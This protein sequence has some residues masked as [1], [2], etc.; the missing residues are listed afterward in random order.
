MDK[1]IRILK[2]FH[3]RYRIIPFVWLWNFI[4]WLPRSIK[5]NIDY[6]MKAK[7]LADNRFLYGWSQR[8]PC[9]Y[10]A[11]DSTS[12]DPHYVYHTSWA[13]RIIVRLKPEYHTDIS[14]SLF[15][16]GIASAATPIRFYDYRPAG[17]KLRG[18]DCGKADVAN[19]PFDDNSISSLSCMHVMEHIGLGRYGDP[20]DP[21]GDLKGIAE[22]KR[23]LAHGGHLLF[24]VP[25]GGVAKLYYNAHR[26]YT[27]E[28]IKEYFEGLELKEF[29][30][31][32]DSG[33]FIERA[34]EDDAQKQT[35]GC[36]CFLFKKRI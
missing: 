21:S 1:I 16:A 4:H 25:I 12:F 28:Q 23:V 18:L 8:W 34:D 3:R 10:D 2:K 22:L 24:V 14:S 29:A 27:L 35:Y 26:V 6:F 13:A 19:L 31:V 15:F 5:Y 17:L 11:T 30:L 9:L 20:F 32:T 7:K 33:D 36:G